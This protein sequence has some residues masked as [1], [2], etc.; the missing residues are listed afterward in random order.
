MKFTLLATVALFAIAPSI[1]S[2][3][4][5]TGTA[6]EAKA[7]LVKAIAAVKADRDLALIQFQK[8]EAGFKDRDLYPYCVRLR[9]GA[10]L[11]G[12]VSVMAGTDV[13]TLKDT[14]GKAFAAEQYAAASKMSDGQ[15]VEL[16]SYMFPKPG[17]REPS[18]LKTSY[19]ARIG[20]IYCGVGWYK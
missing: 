19:I 9:D 13:R 15:I 12:P 3:Q 18:V 16:G 17:T 7:M 20:H 6:E 5:S 4:Q 1:A 2:A 11:S 8:G 14:N 10:A